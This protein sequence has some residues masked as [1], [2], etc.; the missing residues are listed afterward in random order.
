[1]YMKLAKEYEWNPIQCC[2]L[3]GEG[4]TVD[5]NTRTRKSRSHHRKQ[6]SR[7]SERGREGGITE[8]GRERGRERKREIKGR[9][10]KGGKGG[11]DR[12]INTIQRQPGGISLTLIKK[13]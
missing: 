7:Q 4:N 5:Q 6:D 9:R 3:L 13:P 11:S 12:E 1:M 10:E 8:G 2:V